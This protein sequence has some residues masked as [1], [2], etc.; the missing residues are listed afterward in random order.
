MPTHIH[1]TLIVGAGFTGIG[2][3]IKLTQAGVDDFVILERVGPRRRNLAGQ[4]VS[5]CGVRCPVAAVLVLLRQEPVWSRAYSPAGEICEHIEDMADEFD[6]RRR[7]QFGVE[8]NGLD[9]DEDDGVWTV[10]TKGRKRSEK[11]FQARTVVLA[12]GPLPDH[13]WP[14]IR[15]LDTYQGHK[16][17]SA[18]WDHD[19]DF[20][21]KR[22][23]VIGTG[24]SAVQIVPELV[25]QAEFVKVFQRT[26]GWVLPRLD[27]A[28]PA[29]AKT[30]FAKVP[31]AQE[32]ARQ[33]L[34]WGHEVTATAL[35]W[36]TPL[37]GLVARLGKAHLHSAGEG[38]VAATSAHAGLHPGLQADAGLQRLLPGAAAR[39]LQA[40][41]LADRHGQ[42]GR[43]PHQRR[44]R[45]P[46]GLHRLRH[47]LRRPPDRTAVRGHRLGG[48]SLADEWSGGAQAYKSINAH[49]YPNLFF[50]TGPNSG[51]GHNSLLVFVEGQLDY[52]V[53][54]ITTILGQ[55][56]RYLDV[57]EDVQRRYNERIQKRLTSTT[58]M[59]GCSSW[60]LTADGF[61]A[62][63]YPGFATQYLRQMRDFRFDDY[64]AVARPARAG[65]G[66]R[67]T[68][69]TMRPTDHRASRRGRSRRSSTPCGARHD[70]CDAGRATSSRTRCRSCSM[71]PCDTRTAPPHRRIPHRRPRP[72]GGHDDPQHP[73]L[74]RPG[75]AASAVA[76]RPYR[77]VQRHAPHP[78]AA[79]HLHARPWLQHRARA[80]DAQAWEQGKD[81]GDVLGL[82]TAIAGTWAA[83][84]PTAMAIAEAQRLIDDDAGFERLVDAGSSASTT[85]VR[86]PPWC[87]PS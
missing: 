56:L 32:L 71:P 37:T 48:R 78:V 31:A 86:M 59:S 76:G 2:A 41:R 80:R 65:S 43:H 34:Y 57:R 68:R 11:E 6:L 13:K 66:A 28:T 15:G 49:G 79:D 23:A 22:V 46:S 1:D 42:P 53:R 61:N 24:A 47:R 40:H 50:M 87:G 14:D 73:R 17:H 85:T 39:Q 60:Y 75:P 38:S 3:A 7:I 4:H 74:P 51:P 81:L 25:K 19:Y 21:G 45:T 54:G 64:A 29:A 72:T 12:S 77:A 82:E 62:S 8:V 36:D 83:E 26:P 27:V 35:V 52:A 69:L 16:I 9:F 5:R 10:K 18:R 67:S 44:R 33:A 20:T 30:L 58:W 63:M 84:K 70:G 55:N